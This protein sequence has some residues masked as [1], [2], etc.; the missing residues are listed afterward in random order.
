MIRKILISQPRPATERNPYTEMEA[1]FGVQFDFRQ[2]IHVEGLSAREFRQQHIRWIIPPLF[3]I[4][5]SVLSII[6]VSAKK[7]VSTYRTQCTTIAS[8]KQWET[9][10]KSLSN[11]ASAKSFSARTIDSRTC[12]PPCIVGRMRNT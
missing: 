2:L 5:A 9:T 1:Q 8:P 6:S 11:T 7:C 12:C 4:P 10:C 3:S